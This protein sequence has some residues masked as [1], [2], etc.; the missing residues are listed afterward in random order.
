MQQE[1]V[2]RLQALYERG[3]KNKVRDLS[4]IDARGIREREPYCRVRDQVI[5][6]GCF[7]A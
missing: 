2:P 6:R 1:E 7:C 4:V 3:L 5:F